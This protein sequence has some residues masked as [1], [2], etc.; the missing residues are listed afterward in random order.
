[1]KMK[2]SYNTTTLEECCTMF[3]NLL[4][5]K[6]KKAKTLAA[7][8]KVHHGESN[9]STVFLL[10]NARNRKFGFCADIILIG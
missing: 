8:Q 10:L 4:R 5:K 2:A 6:Q 9:M 1:M 3:R 7:S